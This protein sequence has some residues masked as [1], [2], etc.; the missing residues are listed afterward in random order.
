MPAFDGTGPLGAGSRT[1]RGMGFCWPGGVSP[2]RGGG[3]YGV[4]RGGFPRGGG[5]GRAWGGGRGWGWRSW[6]YGY[7]GYPPAYAPTYAYPG[8]DPAYPPDYGYPPMTPE[9][10]RIVI[11]DD[12]KALEEEIGGLRGRLDE[13]KQAK[14]SGQKPGGKGDKVA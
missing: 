14:A 12:I 7:P 4:G 11:Q 10:E 9:Q 5:R 1:G 8:Y 6:G 2:F 3:F 13:L